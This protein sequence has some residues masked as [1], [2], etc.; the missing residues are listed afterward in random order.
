[1]SPRE[2]RLST[3]A[4]N[5]A[6]SVEFVNAR[7]NRRAAMVETSRLAHALTPGSCEAHRVGGASRGKADLIIVAR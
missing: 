4:L 2:R 1:M 5:L 7:L 3:N 6:R